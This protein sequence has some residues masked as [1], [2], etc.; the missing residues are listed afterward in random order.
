VTPSE[1]PDTNTDQPPTIAEVA[2]LTGRLRELSGPGRGADPVL[3]AAFLAD[4]HALL[5][6]ISDSRHDTVPAAGADRADRAGG[7]GH[8][9]EL[10]PDRA[11]LDPTA[12]GEAHHEGHAALGQA[13]EDGGGLVMPAWM[14]EQAAATV[15]RMAAG[16]DVVPSRDDP[17]VIAARLAQLRDRLA[18]QPADTPADGRA[19]QPPPVVGVAD[20][21]VQRAHRALAEIAARDINAAGIDAAGHGAGQDGRSDS[22]PWRGSGGDARGYPDDGY[23]DDGAGSP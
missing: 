23:G 17:Q 4:K 2:A 8:A 9:R 5:A 13:S 18:N 14:R 16:T 7:G 15:A 20:D 12:P 10:H 3:R 21:A 19:D 1:R 11:Q 22:G 6:R